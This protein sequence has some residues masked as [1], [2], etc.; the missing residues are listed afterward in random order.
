MPCRHLV[1]FS[2]HC[3][4]FFQRASLTLGRLTYN[5][6]D[7]TGIPGSPNLLL[8]SSAFTR[9][10]GNQDLCSDHLQL[11]KVHLICKWS[12]CSYDVGDG[13]SKLLTGFKRR[14]TWKNPCPDSGH[15]QTGIEGQL[16]CSGGHKHVAVV[17]LKETCRL[18]NGG[19]IDGIIS[20]RFFLAQNPHHWD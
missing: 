7:C 18:L 5:H 11:G 1:L 2:Q 3:N 13:K 17:L 16:L 4:C 20:V 8:K 9:F 6:T 14:G 15:I 12:L 10:L 19:D